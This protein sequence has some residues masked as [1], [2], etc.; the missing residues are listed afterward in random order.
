[1]DNYYVAK[2]YTDYPRE[3]EVYVVDGKMYINVRFKNNAVKPVR[4][5]TQ[6]EY[7]KLY[8]AATI[9]VKDPYYKPL[10]DIL[11][12]GDK[13]YITIFDGNIEIVGDWFKA[14]KDCRYH[15]TWG[16]YIVS[17]V[18]V[19]A[20]LP[21]GITPIK[22]EWKNISTGPDT[23]RPK[24][25]IIDHI[26]SLTTTPTSESEYVGTI[27]ERIELTV[28]IEKVCQFEGQ[29]G[30][31]NYHVMKSTDG[32]VFIWNTASKNWGTGTI[33]HIRGTVKDFKEYNG[34]KETVLIRCSEV[35]K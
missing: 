22:L 30:F 3:S 12:F 17:D 35:K 32:N 28:S 20:D 24:A 6:T 19:P 1:M 14:N 8:P 27:G 16:W 34:I 25:A 9:E 15:N 4:A 21:Y 29:Y 33:H 23:L 26:V 10:R 11:G 31:S 2:R 7:Q 18:E 5:Y 13:G